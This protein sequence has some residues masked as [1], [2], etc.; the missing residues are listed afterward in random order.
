MS[1]YFILVLGIVAEATAT[2]ALKESEGFSKPWPLVLVVLGYGVAI[3]CLANAQQG[4]PMSLISSAWSGLG[5]TLIT[6][7]AAVRYQ[8]MPNLASIGGIFMIIV[9]I[10]I[11]N[12]FGTVRG[13]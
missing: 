5:I 13:H 8:Q 4:L 11:V 6:I 3:T 2:L 1:A 7:V 12:L 9:G 10:S